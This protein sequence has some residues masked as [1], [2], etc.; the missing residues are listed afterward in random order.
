[1][2][3]NTNSI[4]FDQGGTYF[5][6]DTL[7]LNGVVEFPDNVT[8]IFQG[9]K[10]AI[11]QNSNGTTDTLTII[12]NH[13]KIVAPITQIFDEGINVNG[14]WVIDCAYPQWF[15]ADVKDKE[16]FRNP[17]I[18]E[19]AADCSLAINKAINMKQVGK[20][21][22]PS[23][24]YKINKPIIIP[25][26]IQ[27][28]GEKGMVGLTDSLTT[29]NDN[30]DGTILV[31]HKFLNQ[32]PNNPTDN[33]M[34]YVNAKVNN[35]ILTRTSKN[36]FLAGQITAISNIC[37]K[38]MTWNRVYNLD[39]PGHGGFVPRGSGELSPKDSNNPI[40]YDDHVYIDHSYNL[41]CIFAI[42]TLK[43]D[44]V[45]FENFI[46]A[47]HFSQNLNLGSTYFD[48]KLIT[49]CDYTCDTISQGYQKKYAFD[50]GFLGDAMIFEHNAIH[51]GKYNKGV[52]ATCCGGGRIASNIIN[53]DVMIDC[54]KALDF[55]N[56]HIEGGKTLTIR[57]SNVATSSNFFEMG[58]EPSVIIKGEH[59]Y[60]DKCIVTMKNDTFLFYDYPRDYDDNN[61][62]G[63]DLFEQ[64]ETHLNSLG[65]RYDIVL[66]KE[67]SVTLTNLYRQW[68]GEGLFGKI[69]LSGINLGKIVYDANDPDETY[70]SLDDFNNYSYQLSKQCVVWFHFLVEK[71]FMIK[72]IT[73]PNIYD[74]MKNNSIYWMG[75]DGFYQYAFQIIYDLPRRF[76]ASST[77]MPSQ[78]SFITYNGD[79]NTTELLHKH[80]KGGILLCIDHGDNHDGCFMLR[81]FRKGSSSNTNRNCDCWFHYVDIPV[82]GTNALYDNGIAI[83]GFTWR[84]ITTSLNDYIIQSF[85]NI[86]NVD[87]RGDNVVCRLNQ[88]IEEDDNNST[89]KKGDVI[90]CMDN[91]SSIIIAKGRQGQNN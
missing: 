21:F 78:N 65:N 61:L 18:W 19:T 79:Q 14:T 23:G 6:T 22:L 45:R 17:Y 64:W 63:D 28:H 3:T 33:F 85:Y 31:A 86:Y 57:C 8:L 7:S 10:I 5:I 24:Y 26:G 42:T 43:V 50:L 72:T 89:W 37:F 76:A 20:V 46:Q 32:F 83:N 15:G 60:N 29:E 16:E 35:D 56:N 59:Q 48:T 82:C 40:E 44:N 91:P 81:L 69:Y 73:G 75:L 2:A 27:L 74:V 41:G 90:V 13:T 51:N 62:T 70:V 34:V 67:S 30:N 47:V 9:G 71:D 12:G 55:S 80:Q 1:M 58:V 25:I 77:L 87:Y 38:C 52:R 68:L 4:P 11:G 53:A 54:C 88:T 84:E 39:Q 66:D 36:G 49:N